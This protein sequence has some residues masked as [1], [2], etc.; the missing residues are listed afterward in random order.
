MSEGI[1]IITATTDD[2]GYTAQC[3]VTVTRSTVGVTESDE[4]LTSM[5]DEIQDG[6]TDNL[7]GFSSGKSAD[8]NAVEFAGTGSLF[9]E[10]VF[11]D[12]IKNASSLNISFKIKP[13]Y[14]QKKTFGLVDDEGNV[15]FAVYQRN[16][17]S[18][19]GLL[20]GYG[21]KFSSD[22][23]R[24]DTGTGYESPTW[25]VEDSSLINTDTWYKMDLSVDFTTQKMSAR[26]C[27][28]E[29]VL[30]KV[31]D[32]SIDASSLSKLWVTDLYNSSVYIKDFVVAVP[33]TEDEPQEQALILNKAEI[34]A[35]GNIAYEIDS[36]NEI[37]NETLYTALYSGNGVLIG[38]NIGNIGAF[39]VDEYD[40]YKLKAFLWE[41]MQPVCSN[42]ETTVQYNVF[43]TN[44]TAEP[45]A[46]P[47][48][49]PTTTPTPIEGIQGS[50]DTENK[51]YTYEIGNTDVADE[52]GVEITDTSDYID[53]TISLG[54]YDYTSVDEGIRFTSS[55]VGETN[56]L[57][58]TKR[59]IAITPKVS[60]TFN[61]SILFPDAA[62]NKKHRLYYV[63][64]GS[65][66]IDLTACT[67]SSGTT[68][69]WD[70]T[71]PELTNLEL[72]V[73]AG[74]TYVLYT[75]Q[76]SGTISAMSFEY[77]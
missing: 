19:I 26:I 30:T 15:I 45:S 47:T 77:E 69:G 2:G 72:E 21:G 63:D 7:W 18:P 11:D 55:S 66:E 10:K 23:Y 46:E 73:E 34:D 24:L 37:E 59:Y 20:A 38:I 3:E 68:I 40:D 70:I 75:Y 6:T 52:A 50:D 56:N 33:T 67:K 74:H 9:A 1:A 61:V 27:S 4:I 62:S 39:K 48:V 31:S 54:E 71:T 22:Y 25:I 32:V 13:D 5:S 43:T 49:E 65:D 64:F 16:S 12:N 42:I 41:N 35:D 17:G 8:D 28:E 53:M 51:I 76:K 44:P 58:E 60:G 57:T 36:V 14:G 29:D